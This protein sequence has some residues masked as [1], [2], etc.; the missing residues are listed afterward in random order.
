MIKRIFDIF[1]SII[2]LL[3]L[4][5]LLL[6]VGFLIKRDGGPAFYKQDR[7]GLN[8]QAFRIWKLRSMVVNADKIGGYSTLASDSRIT[9]IG[10]FIRRTSIDELPQLINVILGEMS[11]VGPRPNVPAQQSEYTPKQWAIRNSVLPGITGLAQAEL[12]SKASWEQRWELDKRYVYEKSF[13]LDLK[14]IVKTA[15]KLFSNNGN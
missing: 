7:V 9:A 1:V 14:I 8:G 6:V 15:L 4:S 10:S 13:L 11:L 2:L 12:R 5:P 3:L